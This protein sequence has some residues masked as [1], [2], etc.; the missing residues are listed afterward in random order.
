M[1]RIR[2]FIP[3]VFCLALSV[4][5]STPTAVSPETIRSSPPSYALDVTPP[6]APTN[7]SAE[8]VSKD[9]H[10]ATVRV[11]WTDNSAWADEWVTCAT[12]T[13]ASGGTQCAY[14][15]PEG[16]ETFYDDPA[17][18]TG[19]RTAELIVPSGEYTFTMYTKRWVRP[20]GESF[21]YVLTSVPA[22]ETAPVCAKQHC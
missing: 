18:P 5:C 12:F 20:V 14:A 19:V 10:R 15:T 6:E 11:Q 3:A 4:A 9:G 17:N 1:K 16:S 8:F 7:I 13:P 2:R 22:G 21:S